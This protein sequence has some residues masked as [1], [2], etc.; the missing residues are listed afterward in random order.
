MESEDSIF[1]K[2]CNL[3]IFPHNPDRHGTLL[4][5]E[6]FTL[7]SGLNYGVPQIPALVQHIIYEMLND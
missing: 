6:N 5:G 3:E 2:F 7:S 1:V 4:L